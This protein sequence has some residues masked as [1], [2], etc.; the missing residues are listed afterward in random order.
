MKRFIVLR[1]DS[2]Q[3]KNDGF[4]SS[5]LSDCNCFKEIP[6]KKVTYPT[7]KHILKSAL[8]GN[9]LF[10]QEGTNG[11]KGEI[12]LNRPNRQPS[13]DVDPQKSASQISE[14]QLFGGFCVAVET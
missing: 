9:M 2:F 5:I 6:S 1:R 7:L 13:S 8:G 12:V 10:C 4:K 11:R 3:T 14:W